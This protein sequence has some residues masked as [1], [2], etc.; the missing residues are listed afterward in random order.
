MFDFQNMIYEVVH[1]FVC[2]AISVECV[3]CGFLGWHRVY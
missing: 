3:L 2:E 1:S